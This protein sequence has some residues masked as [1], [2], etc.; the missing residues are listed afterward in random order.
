MNDAD[1][2]GIAVADFRNKFQVGVLAKRDASD[3]S[4]A[5]LTY[6][7]RLY[8]ELFSGT[9]AKQCRPCQDGPTVARPTSLIQ[10][11][12]RGLGRQTITEPRRQ[13]FCGILDHLAFIG[14]RQA[15]HD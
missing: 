1:A 3:Q 10:D 13:C 9:I 12:I 15:L 4:D 5:A 2:D 6:V 8:Q 7:E 11:A 14:S